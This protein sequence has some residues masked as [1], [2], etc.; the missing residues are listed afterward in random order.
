MTRAERK[1]LERALCAKPATYQ[2]TL[3]QIE[4]IKHNAILAER[5]KLKQ[6]IAKEVG[7]LVEKEWAEREAALAGETEEERI[8]KV[9]ALLMSIPAKVLCEKFRWKPVRDE[10][11]HRSKLLQFSEAVVKEVNEIC[12]SEVLDIRKIQEEVWEKYGVRYEVK[13]DDTGGDS[14]G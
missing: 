7:E 2:Y 1:R 10:N 14:V 9:L 12:S 11:D 6:S 3:A 8:L 4:E 13:D 5:E